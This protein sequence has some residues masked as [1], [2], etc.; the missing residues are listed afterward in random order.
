[1][2]VSATPHAGHGH[3][4][5]FIRKYIFSTDHKIIR[6]QFLISS[7]IFLFLGGFLAMGVRAQLGWPHS[8]IPIF[9]K[10]LWGG[11][12]GGRMPPDTYNMLFSMHA[13]VII[14]FVIVP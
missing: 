1:M 9:G 13:A 4:L 5:G 14:F 6:I 10:W 8:D 7:I 12:E 11:H 3:E 2:S